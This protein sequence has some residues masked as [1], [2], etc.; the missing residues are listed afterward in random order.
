MSYQGNIKNKL[1]YENYC[2]IA[3]RDMIC[4]SVIDHLGRTA[5]GERQEGESYLVKKRS[6]LVLNDL[7]FFQYLL[8]DAGEIT[9]LVV[10]RHAKDIRIHR[11]LEHAVLTYDKL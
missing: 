4:E 2:K 9:A 3:D 6:Y 8:A 5:R 10:A 11:A 7:G 1:Y